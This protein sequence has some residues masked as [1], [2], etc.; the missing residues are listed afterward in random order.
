MDFATFLKF[1]HVCAALIWVGGG[2][3]MVVGGIARAKS[4]SPEDQ[5]AHIRT[6]AFLGTR[7]FMPA[8]I[9]TLASGVALLFAAGWGWQPFTIIGLAGIVFTAAFGALVLGPSCEK[10]GQTAEAWGAVSALPMLRR[11]YRLAAFDY[12][13]QFAIIFLMVVKPGWQ[14]IAIFAGLGAVVTLAALAAFRPLPQP[15]V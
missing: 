7:L 11:I 1:V 5:M 6:V 8:S 15:S 3:V 4:A 14:D 12:A 13:V 2:F 9:L 10:A